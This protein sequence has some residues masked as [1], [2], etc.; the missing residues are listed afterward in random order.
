MS[1]IVRLMFVFLFCV[2]PYILC[3]LC[4]CIVLCICLLMCIVAFFLFIC[5]QV[6]GPLPPGGNPIAVNKHHIISYI[7]SYI[8]YHIYHISY[9]ISYISYHI[10]Y[11]II[12][13]NSSRRLAAEKHRTSEYNS[14]IKC[15]VIA[16]HAMK[17]RRGSG[18]IALLILNLGARRRSVVNITPRPLYP[19]E[20][21]PAPTEQ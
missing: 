5:V 15:K 19:R 17:A 1:I 10:I 3:A 9:H 20:I 18:D 14:W 2:L 7:I 11:H 21:T 8:I 16:V 12:K 4:F 13:H 6:Y